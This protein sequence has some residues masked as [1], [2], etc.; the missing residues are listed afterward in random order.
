MSKAAIYNIKIA[1]VKDQIWSYS[2]LP[3]LNV[4]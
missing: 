4:L 1:N 3:V 2:I